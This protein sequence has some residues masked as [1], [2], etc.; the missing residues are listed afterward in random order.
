MKITLKTAHGYLSFQPP[1]DGVSV[2]VEYRDQVG[3]WEQVELEGF[4]CPPPDVVKPDPLGP[5]PP[6][7]RTEDRDAVDARVTWWLQYYGHLTVADHDYWMGVIFDMYHEGHAVGWTADSYWPDK[8]R[9]AYTKTAARRLPVP[10]A[11]LTHVVVTAE[12]ADLRGIHP[13]NGTLSFWTDPRAQVVE[14][15]S[16]D[17]RTGASIR[18]LT[19]GVPSP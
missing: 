5:A 4:V 10:P 16:Q 6:N 9:D 15:V 3:S 19:I 7:V 17:P 8:M 1:A 14:T 2:R 11:E 13:V 18:T 12:V